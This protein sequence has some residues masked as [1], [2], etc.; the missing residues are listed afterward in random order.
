MWED[1]ENFVPQ[2]KKYIIV[3]LDYSSDQEEQDKRSEALKNVDKTP[4]KK[5][6][7]ESKLHPKVKS[8]VDLISNVQLMK[9]TLK[10]FELDTKKMPCLRYFFCFFLNFLK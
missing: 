8:L 5:K 2:K 9:D 6:F 3:D 7:L 4:E 1:R 10:E